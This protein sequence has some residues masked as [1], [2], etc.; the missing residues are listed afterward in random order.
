MIW[1]F[2]RALK[3]LI[4][5]LPGIAI[6]YFSVQNIFPYFDNHLPLG[7]AILA[8]YMLAAYVLIPALIRLARFIHPPKHLPLYCVTP[9]GFAS[10]P[11]NIGLIG[12]RR[13]LIT[14]MEAAGWHRADPHRLPYVLRFIWRGFLGQPYPN[15]PVSY[16]YLFGR[17]QDVAFVHAVEDSLVH[18]HH[19]RFWAAPAGSDWSF[20]PGPNSSATLWV[21][22]S[23]LDVGAA[24]IRHNFQL[25]HMIDPDTDVERELIVQHLKNVGLAGSIKRVKLSSPYRLAN[26]VWR[27]YLHSDGEMAVVRLKG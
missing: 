23:S 16:L 7:L 6:A 24:L 10:D 26:R 13:Q 1:Y 8:T 19:V 9:D 22:A 2:V 12:S 17:K 20:G 5:L 27:G 25:T 15:A 18:R 11:L 3:R 4:V 14:A 21:G